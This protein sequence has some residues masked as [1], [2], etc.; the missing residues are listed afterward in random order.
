MAWFA[1]DILA[2]KADTAHLTTLEHG[3]YF[4]LLQHY[5][6]TRLPLLDNDEALSRIS[7]LTPKQWKT[8]SRKLRAFFVKRGNKLHQKRCDTELDKQD[9]LALQRSEHAKKASHSRKAFKNKHNLSQ[10]DLPDM[11]EINRDDLD[12]ISNDLQ[13]KTRQEK[14]ETGCMKKDTLLIDINSFKKERTELVNFDDFWKIYPHKIGKA[15]AEKCWQRV[16]KK[17]SGQEIILGVERYISEKPPDYHWCNPS[18]FLN[19]ER[20]TD[21]PAKSNGHAKGNGHARGP[22]SVILDAAEQA[23]AIRSEQRRREREGKSKSSGTSVEPF[24]DRK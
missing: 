12:A 13:D 19:Q 20:W 11:A 22:A 1:F 18:T 7:G 15:Y 4:L 6:Q 3:A 17:T 24:L 14:K 2:Y 16:I 21:Q 23:V 5:M 8:M 9:E 10:L